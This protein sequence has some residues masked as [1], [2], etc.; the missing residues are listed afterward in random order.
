MARERLAAI[1]VVAVFP[2]MEAARSAVLA[3]E[4]AG[5]DEHDISLLGPG[6][7]EA[8]VATDVREPDGIVT[9]DIAKTS[10]AGVAAGGS[11]GALAGFI[12]GALAWG[13]PGVGPVVGSAVWAA[14]LGGAGAGA[15]IGGLTAG[16]AV[17]GQSDTW[18]DTYREPLAAGQVLVGVHADTKEALH[19]GEEHLRSQS[20]LRLM[21]LDAQGQPLP[22]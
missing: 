7:E 1:N 12:G 19:R 8:R 17:L 4:R 5:I 22:E 16:A 15:A 18:A 21:R 10:A 14:T 2:D 13:I 6:A 9:R 11:L 3:L 20:P